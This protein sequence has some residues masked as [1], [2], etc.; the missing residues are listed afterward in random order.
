MITSIDMADYN[1]WIPMTSASTNYTYAVPESEERLYWD[2]GHE[3][4]AFTR[5]WRT[6]LSQDDLYDLYFSSNNRF[7]ETFMRKEE[8][9]KPVQPIHKQIS[10]R[11]GELNDLL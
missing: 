5:T 11:L 9:D 8:K 2:G 3:T 7:D 6:T 1:N 10:Y 4:S